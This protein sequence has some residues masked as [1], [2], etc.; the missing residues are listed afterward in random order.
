[1]DFQELENL[2]K[3]HPA[4][5]LLQASYAPLIISFLYKVFVKPNLR[6][7]SQSELVA[8]LEDELFNLREIFGD[9][10]YPKAA[11]FYLNEWTQTEKGWLRKFYPEKLDEPHF[12]L[13]PA[14]EKAIS[15]VE[16]LGKRK[17]VGTESRLLT[18]FELLHQIVA[19]SENDA[20]RIIAELE[21][22]KAELEKQLEQAKRGEFNS[23]DE[24]A[25]KDRF[26]QMSS[27]ARDLLSDFREVE[28]NFR[29]LDRKVREQIATWEGSKGEL[30]EEIFGDRDAIADSD[31]GRS[32]RAFM[33]FVM[34]PSKQ[35]EFS[36]LL[37]KVYELESIRELRPD[38]RLKRIHF[39]WL[40]A[41]EATQKTVAR[42]SHQL[43]RFLDDQV[44]LENKRI[45]KLF[46]QVETK[47]LK[48]RDNL[49]KNKEFFTVAESKIDVDLPME[50]P[51][52]SIP[53]KPDIDSKISRGEGE[54]ID[55]QV[56]FTQFVVDK[57]E[58]KSR[59]RKM[60]HKNSSVSLKEVVE[61]YPLKKGLSE[62]IAYM[63]IA[64][65]DKKAIF[66]E[67]RKER[68]VWHEKDESGLKIERCAIIE[69]ITFFR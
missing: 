61:H 45:M 38:T 44:Y 2:K 14:T 23:L 9:E 22:K 12:D 37:E 50:R 3:S 53:I 40:D 32:F 30:L 63:T 25:L 10:L 42:L 17:F 59:I 56:L 31:Q 29:N 48:L 20:E 15:W 69:R 65:N 58:L 11:S 46:Q 16:A 43:R 5:R 13:T 21:K 51:L 28:Y 34:S 54:K 8:K 19:G 52:Y 55:A 24:T 35:E 4:W 7:I 18:V 33:E 68:F 27:L 36:E 64:G 6:I 57:R 39:D 49:P 26:Q 47:A 41:G 1:M 62:L 66:D 60:L 67:N